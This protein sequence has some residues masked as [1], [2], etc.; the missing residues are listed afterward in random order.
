MKTTAKL[1]ILLLSVAVL[2]FDYCFYTLLFKI[3]NFLL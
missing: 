1:T 2:I 3:L